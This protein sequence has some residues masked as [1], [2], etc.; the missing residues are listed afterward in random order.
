MVLLYAKKISV[1]CDIGIDK[2]CLQ[3]SMKFHEHTS[4]SSL[5]FLSASSLH[6]VLCDFF[7]G[8]S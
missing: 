8:E 6:S 4:L 5:L 1:L 7:W 2:L 3:I